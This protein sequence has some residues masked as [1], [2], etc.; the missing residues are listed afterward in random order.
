[1]L[2]LLRR[3]NQLAPRLEEPSPET[4]K[5]ASDPPRERVTTDCNSPS[6][7]VGL[8]GPERGLRCLYYSGNQNQLTPR[9]EEPSPEIGRVVKLDQLRW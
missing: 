1:M 9:L 5:L 2:V 6:G 4:R 8:S 7:R 3:Q